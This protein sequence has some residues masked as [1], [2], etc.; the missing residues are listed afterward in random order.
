MATIEVSDKPQSSRIIAEP[1]VS[2]GVSVEAEGGGEREK[3]VGVE[4]GEAN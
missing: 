3:V 4:T 1:L 2:L